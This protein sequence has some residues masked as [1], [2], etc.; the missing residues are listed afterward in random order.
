MER[1]FSHLVYC[2]FVGLAFGWPFAPEAAQEPDQALMQGYLRM[3]WQIVALQ[4]LCLAIAA[5]SRS[6]LSSI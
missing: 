4:L 2:T 1:D 6:M 5:E 3:S